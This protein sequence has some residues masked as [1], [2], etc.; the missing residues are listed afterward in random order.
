M[1]TYSSYNALGSSIET[2]EVADN[3]VTLA[4]ME[5]EVQGDILIYGPG[6]MPITLAKGTALQVLRM[7]AG[8][9]AQEWASGGIIFKVAGSYSIGNTQVNW[10]V[11][12]VDI[13]FAASELGANDIIV[14][15]L[16]CATILGGGGNA[17]YKL[18]ILDTTAT[19]AIVAVDAIA[20]A[21]GTVV[22]SIIHISQSEE[23][24]DRLISSCNW[25]MGTASEHTESVVLDTNDANVLTTAF[26]LRL[27]G[28]ML[29]VGTNNC[30]IGYKI[31]IIKGA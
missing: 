20:Q 25:G 7:N 8:V 9:T 17:Q 27:N 3:A 28:K 11:D 5:H 29:D 22:T 24:N 21:A 15:E 1:P 10:D 18:D 19:G 16:S 26:T 4:K 12:H 13:T 6:G 2:S 14:V 23:D 31:Y 30:V